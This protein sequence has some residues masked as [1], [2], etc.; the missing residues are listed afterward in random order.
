MAYLTMTKAETA[1]YDADD[2]ELIRELQ[3]IAQAF[4]NRI[5]EPVELYTYDGVLAYVLDPIA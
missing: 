1:R 5:S 4:A 3:T 2:L